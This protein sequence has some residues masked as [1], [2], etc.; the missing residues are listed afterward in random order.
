V[1]TN[2]IQYEDKEYACA[3]VHDIT[4]RKQREEALRTTQDFLTVL[5]ENAP[6]S[7]YMTLAD[8]RVR[9]VNSAWEEQ[10]LCDV[11]ANPPW[12]LYSISV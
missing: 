2:F 8:D 4:E 12:S 10:R 1:R 5:M 11:L 7:I 3:I 9:L 6:I